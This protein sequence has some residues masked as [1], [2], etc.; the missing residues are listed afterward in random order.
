MDIYL[1]TAIAG[2]SVVLIAVVF[3]FYKKITFADYS[4]K[5]DDL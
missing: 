3:S 1:G 4:K 5:Y 2:V